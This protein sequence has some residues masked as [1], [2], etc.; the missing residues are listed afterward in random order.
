[1]AKIRTGKS[2][3]IFLGLL[4][5]SLPLQWIVAVAISIAVH[6]FCHYAAVRIC[7]GQVYSLY[8]SISGLKMQTS[9][10]SAGKELFCA[11]AGPMGGFLLFAASLRFPRLALCALTHSVFNLLPCRPM[12]GGRAVENL[13]VLLYPRSGAR[14]F[15]WLERVLYA[16]VV[17]VCVWA[18]LVLKLG[19]FPLF[20]AGWILAK[21]EFMK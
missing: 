10:L 6:E 4:F 13:L 20:V 16:A 8:I 12:D 17:L 9:S 21:S 15:L 19:I 1:M 14:I 18:S 5:L 7:G 3:W 2:L 11:L